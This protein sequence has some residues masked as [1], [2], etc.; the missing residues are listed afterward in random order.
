MCHVVKHLHMGRAGMKDEVTQLTQE[1]TM[2]WVLYSLPFPELT[3][4]EEGQINTIIMA[5]YREALN[6]PILQITSRVFKLC[7]IIPVK[8]SDRPL[9]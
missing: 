8:K 4:A 6:L 7:F 2:N 3:Y 1:L 5:A 9:S